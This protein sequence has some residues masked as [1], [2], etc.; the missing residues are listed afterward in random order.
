MRFVPTAIEGAWL[1]ET[2]PAGDARGA[3]SRSYC[4]EA[5]REAG[6]AFDPVQCSLS[7]NPARGTLRGMHY[8]HPPHL[9]AKLVLCAAGSIFDVALDLRR[10]SRTFG[11]AVGTHLSGDGARLFYIPEG[12]AH[13]FLTLEPDSSVFYLIGTAFQDGQGAGVRWDDPAFAIEWPEAPVLM[14]DRDASYP[15]FDPGTGG[16][17]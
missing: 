8:Q 10:G 11:K 5:F 17:P 4:R 13:G 1:I 16:V 15:D 6:I 2:D 3:F 7:T 14:S 12:C 9:E